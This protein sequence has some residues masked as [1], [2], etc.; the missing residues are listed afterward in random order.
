MTKYSHPIYKSKHGV[1]LS[2]VTNRTGQGR[3]ARADTHSRSFSVTL[4]KATV[5]VSVCV[6]VVPGRFFQSL[7]VPCGASS[8]VTSPRCN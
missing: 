7:P 5:V 3:A 2:V 1:C 8:D 6:W 4:G